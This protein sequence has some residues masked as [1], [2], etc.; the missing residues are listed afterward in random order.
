V[1][2]MNDCLHRRNSSQRMSAARVGRLRV[3]CGLADSDN[4]QS[5]VPVRPPPVMSAGLGEPLSKTTQS[6]ELAPLV[7]AA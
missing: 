2:R 6:R 1:N 4:N 7:A 3:V 5:F